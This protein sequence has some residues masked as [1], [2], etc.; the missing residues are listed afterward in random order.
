MSLKPKCASR[1]DRIDSRLSP[2]QFFIP[3]AMDLAMVRAT[4][5]DGEFIAYL[6][7]ERSRLRKP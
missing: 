3:A 1:G 5:R 7:T 4:E 6:P 2:P